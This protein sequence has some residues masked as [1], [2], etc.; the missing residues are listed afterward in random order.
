[1][2]FHCLSSRSTPSISHS[3][4]LFFSFSL[5]SG[6]FSF[7][8]QL[9]KK[10]VQERNHLVLVP[11]LFGS[12]CGGS[13][14][15][16]RGRNGSFCHEIHS[17]ELSSVGCQINANTFAS[18]PSAP[19][20]NL[21]KYFL[22]FQRIDQSRTCCKFPTPTALPFFFVMLE[23]F[24]AQISKKSN[25]SK[26]TMWDPVKPL[27]ERICPNSL[28]GIPRLGAE[29][30]SGYCWALPRVTRFGLFSQFG[31]VLYTRF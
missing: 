10:L 15:S 18:D 28:L 1:M 29:K 4:I 25:A 31:M 7:S 24:T 13:A 22:R 11:V 6:S 19:A 3:L 16:S 21:W 8:Q 27:F 14:N 20:E 17:I 12:N 26:A 5:L 9:Y 30:N 2:S 23:H